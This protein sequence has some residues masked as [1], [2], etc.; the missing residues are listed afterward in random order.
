[1]IDKIRKYYECFGLHETLKKILRYI[2]VS[3]RTTYACN[4]VYSYDINE[5]KNIVN[6]VHQIYIFCD[7]EYIKISDGIKNIINTLNEHGFGVNYVSSTKIKSG[8]LL[9]LNSYF[10]IDDMSDKDLFNID[11]SIYIFNS[12]CEKVKIIRDK[13]MTQKK[14][15]IDINNKCISIDG[16]LN[17]VYATKNVG[18]FVNNISIVVLNYNNK[19]VIDKCIDSLIK[20]NKRYSYEIIVV[21]NKSTDGSYETLK[22]KYKN[23]IRLF[24][25]VKNGCSSGRNLGVSKSNKEYILFLDSDQW[26]CDDYWLDTFI[27]IMRYNDNIGAVGWAGGWFNKKGYA[28]HTFDNFEY[29]YMPPQGLFRKDI[30]YLGSGGMFLKKD[31]FFKTGGFDEHYDPTCYEDTDLSLSIRNLGFDLVY[32]PYISIMH[33]AHQTT[34]EGSQKHNQLINEKGAYFVKKWKSKNANLLKKYIK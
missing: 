7:D 10:V 2:S 31:V 20:Y 12:S 19:F 9:P 13:C 16:I 4:G 28:Y 30:G 25:N 11:D 18:N 26:V 3:I 15:I 24:R 22:S 8:K 5:K 21:D 14:L 32:S 27:D 6:K 23:S 1:M 34:K 17:K 29:R 33:N